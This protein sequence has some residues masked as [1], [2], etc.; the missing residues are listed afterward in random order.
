M[1]KRE[2]SKAMLHRQFCY[3]AGTGRTGTHW[4]KRLLDTSCERGKVATFH[5]G[6]PKRAKTS[7]RRNPAEF[8]SNYLL[9]LMVSNQS[10][11]AYVECNPALLEHVALTYGIQDALAVIPGGFL[12]TP[13]RGV[14]MVRSPYAYVAS[15]RARGY[16][17]NW[18]NYPHAR[19]VYDLGDG[20]TK[21]PAIEQYAVAWA[22]KNNFYHSLTRLGVQV[23]KFELLFDRRVTKERFT[24]R[25][26]D[27]FVTFGITLIRDPAHWWG[28]RDERAA[29][30]N[31]ENTALSTAER[32]T[33]RTICG[34]MMERL[35]YD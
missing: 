26:E 17:W 1:T 32:E 24:K 23:L 28:L 33:V 6:F 11:Q 4:I 10:A 16:G 22:L 29:A 25:I 14:L 12:A 18:W 34:P 20:Y 30:K 27:I 8:F 31:K 21:R 13:T 9:N 5:D 2:K 35:G 19:T 3:I 15:M 7:G